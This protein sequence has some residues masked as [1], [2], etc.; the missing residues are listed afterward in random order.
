MKGNLLRIFEDVYFGGVIFLF[1]EH[2]KTSFSLLTYSINL[3]FPWF[4]GFNLLEF[5]VSLIKIMNHAKLP[6]LLEIVLHKHLIVPCNSYRDKD[7][8][9]ETT[10][11]ADMMTSILL[12]LSITQPS[13]PNK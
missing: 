6:L 4:A 5:H 9:Y 13:S 8:Y 11:S 1:L 10:A 2:V 12:I 3:V 7:L